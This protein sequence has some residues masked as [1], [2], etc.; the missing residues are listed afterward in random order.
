MSKKARSFTLE[1]LRRTPAA[2]L[3]Q[4]LFQN[5]V[6]NYS[7]KQVKNIPV[8]KK[9]SKA[10]EWL[11]VNLAY[12]CN[13]NALELK[14]ELRFDEYRKWRFDWAIPAL[15]VAIEY[16]GI[17]SEKSRHT[18]MKGYTGDIEK[19]NHATVK[20]WRVI[21]LTAKDYH[22]VITILEQLKTKEV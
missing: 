3:N 18:S 17:F 4:H 19:Y 21:R 9:Q 6:E 1:D 2:R 8:V 20:G 13:E 7:Q 22:G 5:P 11:S 10:K 16:E 12:W 15:M 14:E